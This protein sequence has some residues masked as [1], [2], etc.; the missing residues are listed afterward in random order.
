[1][2]LGEVPW[3]L[4]LSF[5]LETTDLHRE[6]FATATVFCQLK[7]DTFARAPCSSEPT[8]DSTADSIKIYSGVHSL[9]SDRTF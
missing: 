7:K 6:D 3:I 8:I 1:M 9:I 2:P 5:E 4:A